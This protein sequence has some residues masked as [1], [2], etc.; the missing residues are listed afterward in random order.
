MTSEMPC[1]QLLSKL[2]SV[3]GWLLV[4]ILRST[5]HK[6]GH[7]GDISQANVLAWYGE[8]KT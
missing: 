6:I 3:T 8:N 2:Y 4:K 7:F 5:R 1:L